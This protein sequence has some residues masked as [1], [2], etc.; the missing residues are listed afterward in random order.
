MAG[1]SGDN[2]SYHALRALRQAVR[3]GSNA[4]GANLAVITTFSF[5]ASLPSLVLANR[6]NGMRRASLDWS[7]R[8]A[9]STRFLPEDVSGFGSLTSNG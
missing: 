4:R 3:I 9:R 1:D 6:I 7:G 2:N 5:H 8:S